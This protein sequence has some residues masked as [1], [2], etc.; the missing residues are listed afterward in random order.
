MSQLNCKSRED[1]V[2]DL[3]REEHET[4]EALASALEYWINPKGDA[5]P[6]A[7]ENPTAWRLSQVLLERL[8]SNEFLQRVDLVLGR[9]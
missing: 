1:L 8:S 3:I 2:S 5:D 4:L 6:D 9:G 7:C